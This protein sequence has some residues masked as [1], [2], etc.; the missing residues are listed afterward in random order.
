MKA[1]ALIG[2]VATLVTGMAPMASCSHE[3]TSFLP[4]GTSFS[5]GYT[6]SYNTSEGIKSCSVTVYY[7]YTREECN[8]CHAV[9]QRFKVDEKSVHSEPDHK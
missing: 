4:D 6:H 1:L 9:L 3:H 8:S 2:L 5:H 7:V